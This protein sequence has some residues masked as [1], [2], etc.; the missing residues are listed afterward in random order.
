MQ[1]AQSPSSAPARWKC[2]AN[3]K[4]TLV[5]K[6]MMML[7]RTTHTSGQYHLHRVRR[8]RRTGTSH[9]LPVI[10]VSPLLTTWIKAILFTRK[11]KLNRTSLLV[12][13]WKPDDEHLSALFTPFQFF[14]ASLISLFSIQWKTSGKP[15]SVAG[16]KALRITT[17]SNS[18][19]GKRWL[20]GR[21]EAEVE[22]RESPTHQVVNAQ[23][24][25]GVHDVW[26]RKSFGR[27]DTHNSLYM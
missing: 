27:N 6:A 16:G 21:K 17:H 2:T 22:Q 3:E 19:K 15:L 20:K 9:L 11:E 10:K 8:K 1:N 14:P 26:Q 4:F 23:D 12:A 5:R 13:E 24:V 7:V 18:E 25:P